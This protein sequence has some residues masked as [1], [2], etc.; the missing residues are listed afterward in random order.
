MH[1]IF[2]MSVVFLPCSVMR[3]I[4][5]NGECFEEMDQGPC[6]AQI[7]MFYYE[8]ENNTCTPFFYGGCEGNDNKFETIEE[9]KTRCGV[10]PNERKAFQGRRPSDC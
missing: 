4:E 10:W 7:P 1:L 3:M 6:R 9:C 8:S 5:W 2:V